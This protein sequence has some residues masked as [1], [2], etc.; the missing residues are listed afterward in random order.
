M[1]I[2][3]FTGNSEFF[4]LPTRMIKFIIFVSLL[5]VF[6]FIGGTYWVGNQLTAPAPTNI[7]APPPFLPTESV[8]FTNSRGKLLAGWYIPGRIE[9]GTI[10]LMHAIRSNRRSM[11]ERAEFLHQAGYSILLFD[12]QAHGESEGNTITFGALE[13]DDAWAAVQFIAQQRPSAPIG[14]IGFSLGGAAAVFNGPE[15]PADALILEA[16]YSTLEQ[17]VVN[18]IRQRVGTL[19][20]PLA[21]FLLIH[22]E[23]HYG[24]DPRALRPIEA[25]RTIDVPVFVIGGTHD[26]HTLQSET[27]A[28]FSVAPS[29]K[30]LWL[31]KGA[32]HQDLYAYAPEEYKTRVLTFLN[33]HIGC[34]STRSPP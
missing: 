17:A 22:L 26:L 23:S 5:G 3:P 14:V 34:K 6:L 2:K 11:L 7:G 31:V 8:Q 29:P 21:D 28:L 20:R 25:I 12:F 27:K 18:R 33:T 4:R 16:V 13:K 19:A 30:E 1:L 32:H 24:M 10:V 9:C 15:L